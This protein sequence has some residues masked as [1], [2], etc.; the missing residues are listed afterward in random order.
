MN[1]NSIGNIS[2]SS[3]RFLW[4]DVPMKKR[5]R[6]AYKIEI[7]EIVNLNSQRLSID[8]WARII[9]SIG[10]IQ[11]S[12]ELREIETK[13]RE[14][15]CNSKPNFH[16]NGSYQISEIDK[17]FSFFFAHSR[18]VLFQMKGLRFRSKFLSFSFSIRTNE[19]VQFTSLIFSLS[20][21]LKV[22]KFS[23]QSHNTDDH[24][25]FNKNRT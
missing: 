1:C 25:N 20:G 2:L 10:K 13:G 16:I 15:F 5:N 12:I 7:V 9:F 23:I 24:A 18:K 4:N 17:S 3:I 11:Y 22:L 14:S 19:K 8:G 21:I 6:K